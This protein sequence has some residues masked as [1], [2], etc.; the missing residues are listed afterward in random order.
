MLLRMNLFL[1]NSI[2][3]TRTLS[4]KAAHKIKPAVNNPSSNQNGDQ[5][6]TEVSNED[7]ANI[8]TGVFNFNFYIE[9]DQSFIIIFDRSIKKSV[10]P[11][12][13]LNIFIIR[14]RISTM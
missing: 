13:D 2:N 8:F 4:R 9:Q 3:M 1:Q 11:K 10:N 5:N 6:K 14:K 7:L 12:H